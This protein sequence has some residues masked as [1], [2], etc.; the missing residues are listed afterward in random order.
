MLFVA[1]VHI[2]SLGNLCFHV[3]CNA[4]Q[5]TWR[6]TRVMRGKID[7]F[8]SIKVEIGIFVVE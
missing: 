4:M 2:S 8:F 3:S 1:D 5:G 7:I 6:A